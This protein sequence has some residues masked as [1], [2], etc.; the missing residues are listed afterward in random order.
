LFWRQFSWSQP[1][2]SI[3]KWM[4]RR[5]TRFRRSRQCSGGAASRGSATSDTVPEFQL[6]SVRGRSARESLSSSIN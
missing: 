3:T 4:K 5:L 6:W 2:S 1:Y